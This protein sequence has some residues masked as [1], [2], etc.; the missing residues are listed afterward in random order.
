M[1]LELPRNYSS[2]LLI[3]FKIIILSVEIGFLCGLESV[4]GYR[5]ADG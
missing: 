3:I 1:C 2:K 5:V 4:G